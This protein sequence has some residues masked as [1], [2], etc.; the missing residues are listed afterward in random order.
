MKGLVDKDN[1]NII[2]TA[3]QVFKE[4]EERL[5]ILNR[6]IKNIKN[7]QFKLLEMKIRT[8]EMKNTVNGAKSRLDIAEERLMNLKT[9]Q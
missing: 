7:I 2:L 5:K 4:L 9:Q 1:K 8:S 3:F 6:N